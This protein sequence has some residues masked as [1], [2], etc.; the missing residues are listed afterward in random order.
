MPEDPVH[1]NLKN[2]LKEVLD[3]CGFI[4]D[5]ELSFNFDGATDQ[6]GK[7]IENTSIDVASLINYNARKC[8]ILFEVKKSRP[9]QITRIFSAWQS[10]I[11]DIKKGNFAVLN[12][13]DKRIRKA[14]LGNLD[15]IVFCLV[16]GEKNVPRSS[17][18]NFYSW[19]IDALKYY[20]KVS[21]VLGEWTRYEIFKDF[22]L[23]LESSGTYTEDALKISQ[24]NNK[25]YI[26]GMHP[27]ALLK[28]C[29]VSRRSSTKSLA[30]QRLLSKNRV[31]E[32]HDYL[33]NSNVLLPNAI[34]LAFD[35]TST[36]KFDHTNKKIDLPK[37]YCSAWI[38]D[39][40]HRV[41]GF[42]KNKKYYGVPENQYKYFQLP[43]IAFKDAD[44]KTQSKVFIDINYYQKK[45][46]PSLLCD[47]STVIKNL[48]SELTWASLLV[49][50]LNSRSD[51]LQ[52]RIKVSELDSRGK[53]ISLS[54]AVKY[55]L[56][57]S[58]LGYNKKTKRYDGALYK[59]APFNVNA[60]FE[61][62]NNQRMFEKQCKLLDR[63]FKAI[64]LNTKPR[65]STPKDPWENVR[66]YS[67]LKPTGVNALYLV[68]NRILEKYPSAGLNL[69][70]Y[71]Q[72]IN[73]DM[74]ERKKVAKYGGG[75]KGF[76]GLADKM[77]EV[78]NRKNNDSL[79]L[80]S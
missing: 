47:L 25:L 44:E 16:V 76:R 8:L 53:K 26:F 22:D 64:Y 68:L 11:S 72:P 56:L 7:L 32:I 23:F 9:S 4:N 77:L 42:L 71:L 75:W 67:L 51:V 73:K 52:D 19:S 34:I 18:K 63:F 1:R 66:H 28:I 74:F 79:R 29:Y 60:K 31:R 70:T 57:E 50:E 20:D 30:Y 3:R 43:V 33:L 49:K 59:Y 21:S 40:Q 54:S 38:V 37:V 48:K 24:G 62:E 35:N 17:R 36:I 65:R 45:I 2:K 69:D 13:D 27:D 55:G 6:D 78:I 12:S 15:Y 58:L 39:G 80:Y 61:N 14:D 5:R 41:F 10:H 46:D